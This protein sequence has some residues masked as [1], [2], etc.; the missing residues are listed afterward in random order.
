MGARDPPLHAQGPLPPRGHPDGPPRR[1]AGAPE[2]GQAPTPALAAR[3]RGALGP[4]DRG[5]RVRGV[6]RP[7]Q[8]GPEGRVRRGFAGRAG[9][10]GLPA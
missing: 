8:A 2:A 1:R 5:L 10:Q 6:Q 4:A 9:P 3:G 7:H